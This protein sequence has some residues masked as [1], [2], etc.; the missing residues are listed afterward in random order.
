[1]LRKDTVKYEAVLG[2]MCLMSH[3][4]GKQWSSSCRYKMLLM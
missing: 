1:L 4:V 3:T 2:L